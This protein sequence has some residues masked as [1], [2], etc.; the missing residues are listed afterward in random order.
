[1]TAM[2]DSNVLLSIALTAEERRLLR[3]GLGEWGGPARCTDELALAM[4]FADVKDLFA[5]S[6]R[7]V[8]S[9]E[10][11]SP[12]SAP[13]WRRVLAATEIVFAS[14]VFGSGVDWPTTTGLLDDET[15]KLLRSVQRKVSK[16][17]VRLRAK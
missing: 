8:N 12:L 15:I 6:D 9:L 13:D 10:S 16:G 1:M 11:Q 3:H 2:S 4:G 5:Q 14:D 7:L 17:G